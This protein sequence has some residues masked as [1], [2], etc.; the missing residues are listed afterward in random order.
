MTLSYSAFLSAHLFG[1]DHFWPFWSFFRDIPGPKWGS[2][3]PECIQNGQK[4]L[5]SCRVLQRAS[6]WS[7]SFSDFRTSKSPIISLTKSDNITLKFDFVSRYNLAVT[8]YP[9]YGARSLPRC[10]LRSHR[11][12]FARTELA[13]LT[14]VSRGC[15]V[16]LGHDSDRKKIIFYKILFPK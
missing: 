6:F 15:G 13:S 3:P 1:Q 16:T 14:R 8:D 10:S 7:A 11:A 12:R 2:R 9:P 4:Y 5:F